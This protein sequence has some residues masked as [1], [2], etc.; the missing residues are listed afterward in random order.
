MERV[1]WD[2]ES[3][4]ENLTLLNGLLNGLLFALF[5]VVTY[6]L[7]YWLSHQPMRQSM[8]YS[9]SIIGISWTILVGFLLGDNTGIERVGAWWLLSLPTAPFL[10]MVMN[11]KR[12]LLRILRMPTLQEQVNRRA[13][14]LEKRERK[15]VRTAQEL[16][17]GAPVP[18]KIQLGSVVKGDLLPDSIGMQVH[19]NWLY[20]N[21]QA[22]NQHM[23]ILGNTGAGKSETI[24]R[25]IYE[26]LA[27][28]DRN[29]YFIDGKGDGKLAEEIRSLSMQYGRGLAPIF[30]LGFEQQGAI[31]NGFCGQKETIY[32][33]LCS[34][35]GVDEAEGNALYYADSNRD[36]LQLVCYSPEGPPRS[37]GEIR[38]RLRRDWLSKAWVGN[39]QESHLIRRL[40]ERDLDGLAKRIRPLAREFSP[41]VGPEGFSLEETR[42]AIFSIRTQSVGDTG[43]RFLNFLLEDFKDFLGKRQ[44]HP[45]ILVIDEF[46][47][48][49][50]QSI[51]DIVMVAR[52]SGIGVVLATQHTESLG[53][54][55]T[56]ENIL[57]NTN[58]KIVMRT[59]FPEDMVNLAGTEYQVET[60]IQYDENLPT[61]KGSARVQH[62]FKVD[63]NEVGQL[64]PGQA[65]IIRQR[66]AVKVVINAVGDVE[67]A[68]PQEEQIRDINNNIH[69]D[70]TTA[71]PPD[72]LQI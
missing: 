33:R 67:L 46:G 51:Q 72:P 24:K 16:N 58:T 1:G 50:N 11:L 61:G 21:N 29:V 64:Q 37:F 59:D 45:A 2:L 66:H 7:A 22:I 38:Q 71:S 31:Y 6:P 62:T 40:D 44:K 3:K 47:Q 19:A 25:L 48:F 65:F 70:E 9:L 35:A 18:D 5:G 14:R 56:K 13:K 60:S 4:D 41:S 49:R 42:C 34:L 15:L 28:T 52:S 63:P 20:L 57:A 68:P 23:F 26:V 53:D 17:V 30:K 8:R 69:E 12:A 10:A 55:A 43:R 36:L 32:N 54:R 27:Y 39:E